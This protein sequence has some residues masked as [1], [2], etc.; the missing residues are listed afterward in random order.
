MDATRDLQPTYRDTAAPA[1]A[2]QAGEA[3]ASAVSCA[4]VLAGAFVA[5]ALAL[6]LLSLGVGLG[7]SSVSPWDGAGTSAKRSASRPSF[8]SP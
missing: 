1:V 8:G 3:A 7:L 2:P 6:I 4:A 5:A